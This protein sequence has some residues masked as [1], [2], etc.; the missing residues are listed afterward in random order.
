M[1]VMYNSGNKMKTKI[2]N[3]QINVPCNNEEKLPAAL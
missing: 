1:I 3:V 2:E